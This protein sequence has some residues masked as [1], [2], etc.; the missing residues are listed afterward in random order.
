MTPCFGLGAGGAS[1]FALG[2]GRKGTEGI[3]GRLSVPLADD[4]GYSVVFRGLHNR[5]RRR[6]VGGPCG[7]RGSVTIS[8][9]FSSASVSQK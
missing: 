5:L 3:F 2:A 1:P 7:R 4:L 8:F 9:W 6:L